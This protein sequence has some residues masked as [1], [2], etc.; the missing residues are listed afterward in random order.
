MSII[1]NIILVT[2]F[3]PPF[4]VRSV[5]ERQKH[6]VSK[7]PRF[8]VKKK[9]MVDILYSAWYTQIDTFSIWYNY[10]TIRE[11]TEIIFKFPDSIRAN[12][13][14]TPPSLGYLPSLLIVV[15]CTGG[16]CCYPNLGHHGGTRA[17]EGFPWR[18]GCTN[19]GQQDRAKGSHLA[20]KSWNWCAANGVLCMLFLYPLEYLS[21]C[22]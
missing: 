14:E 3:V 18:W 9:G 10:S 11:F 21:V 19:R 22:C 16:G 5:S 7:N 4:P 20:F 17:N 8:L 2:F 15:T 1:T 12:L 13:Q 6:A